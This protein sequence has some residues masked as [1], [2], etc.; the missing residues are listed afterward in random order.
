[1]NYRV[2]DLLLLIAPLLLVL[3]L[4]GD[5]DT[6]IGALTRTTKRGRVPLCCMRIFSIA[7][8]NVINVLLLY[9]G[10]LLYAG[11]FFGNLG[12][13]RAIQSLPDFQSCTARITVGGYFAG[14]ALMKIAALTAIALIVWI[15]F[16]RFYSFLGWLIAI[17]LLGMQYI[18]STAI[19]PTSAFN[20]LKFVN[21]A[22]ALE[23]DI[24]F[25][26]YCNLNWFD[27]PSGILTDII[28]A[29]ILVLAVL[30]L[31]TVLLIG[32]LRPG[33]IGQQLETVKDTVV[34]KLNR[35]L[36]VH[37]LFGFEGW[38]L[39]IAE[40]ALV[41]IAVCAVFS[42]TLWNDTR[43]Y[44][45]PIDAQKFYTKYS[46]V[47]TQE[48]ISKAEKLVVGEEDKLE[49]DGQSFRL[50]MANEASE[51]MKNMLRTHIYYDWIYL[52]RY[53]TFL[54]TMVSTSEFAEQ[55]GFT[56][57]LIDDNPYKKM[58]EDSAA[59]RRCCMLLLLFLIFS[60]YGICAYDNRYDTRL[61][62]RSTKN[63]RGAL[64]GTQILWCCMLTAVAVIVCHGIF[65]LRLHT[66]LGFTHLEADMRNL[67]IFR[68]IPFRISL[69]GCIIWLMIQRYLSALLLC[70]IIM[71]VSRMSKTPQRALLLVLVILVLPT[72][73][74]ESGIVH[75]PD[76]LRVLSCCKSEL[77]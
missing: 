27:H 43:F 74:A 55:N 49:R 16:S 62:L 8:L 29:L 11:R 67:A 2:T 39:L 58:I 50:C 61:L 71:I 24:Y 42:F 10:N 9:G 6:A 41:T 72:A 40:R 64:L 12:I 73:L 63:G 33:R 48:N 38:K 1:M 36:P 56:A 3:E 25:T 19:V 4:S 45:Q 46:G 32:L 51:D 28:L 54:E 13:H 23:A 26:Q 47:I 44:A 20:H 30:V 34:R 53:E 21:L 60:F 37:S 65:L 77:I 68:N 31:L 22:S 35:R 15:L 75:M 18:F 7:L 57:Y 17:P 66:D 76:F 5:S 52:E 69:R 70:G 59:E 14:V